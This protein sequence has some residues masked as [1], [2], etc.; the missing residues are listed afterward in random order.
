MCVKSTEKTF[1]KQ[2]KYIGSEKLTCGDNLVDE[3]KMSLANLSNTQDD[4]LTFLASPRAIKCH[5][6]KRWGVDTCTSGR[7]PIA[8]GTSC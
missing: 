2:N 7:W 1:T 8:P 4:L 5:G 3:S 6:N